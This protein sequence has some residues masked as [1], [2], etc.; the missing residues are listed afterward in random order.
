[1]FY[2][3]TKNKQVIHINQASDK[4][5][6]Y[7][8]QCHA[9]LM[10]K[11]G[12]KMKKH[13]SHIKGN[14]CSHHNGES[15]NHH[16]AKKQIAQ[17]LAQYYTVAIEYRIKEKEQVRIADICLPNEQYII[18]F[19]QSVIDYKLLN[20]RHQFYIK[21]GYQVVWL[22]D[23]NLIMINYHKIKLSRFIRH[24][25]QKNKVG[26][27]ILTYNYCHKK[28]YVYYL[29]MSDLFNNY[30]KFNKVDITMTDIFCHVTNYQYSLTKRMA[31]Y[32]EKS[33]YMRQTLKY[34]R[35]VH[36]QLL[37]NIYQL[38]WQI[39]QLPPYIGYIYPQ[40]LFLA[41]HPLVWQ[42]HA[43]LLVQIYRYSP[44]D[45]LRHL[46]A[47]YPKY[48]SIYIDYQTIQLEIK[49][50]FQDFMKQIVQ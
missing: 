8:P 37:K 23:D 26:Y 5:Q 22:L 35:S 34:N 10:I 29:F 44:K 45:I 14:H 33:N 50:M 40:Q 39:N 27:Y 30:V 7:C 2:A 38:G 43:T 47:K 36:H 1:M 3:I 18:E 48:Q 32:Q 6:Y 42:V 19:Q 17:Q 4:E 46:L 21:C 49:T 25:I 11:K 28:Y 24:F 31:T 15:I 12:I 16:Q 20:M 41:C 13:F 9:A